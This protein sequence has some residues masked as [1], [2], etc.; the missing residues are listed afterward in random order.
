MCLICV[1][2]DRIRNNGNQSSWN[3]PELVTPGIQQS[4]QFLVTHIPIS[5]IK[6]RLR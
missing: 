5:L 3:Q 2:K 6:C 4:D 1:L